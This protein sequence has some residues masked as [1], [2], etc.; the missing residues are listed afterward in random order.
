M[1]LVTLNERHNIKYKD[2]TFE[3]Y[4]VSY[5]HVTIN[6]VHLRDNCG[7][8]IT[9]HSFSNI[10]EIIT[11]ASEHVYCDYLRLLFNLKELDIPEHICTKFIELC[12]EVDKCP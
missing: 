10:Y 4:T 3:I 5:T 7:Y 6:E 12:N 9:H 2:D 8:N 11:P 1:S